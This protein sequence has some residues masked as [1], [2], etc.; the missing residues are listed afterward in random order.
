MTE[1]EA[2]QWVRERF[3]ASRETLLSRF[4][5]LVVAESAVQNLVSAATLSSIW[6]RHIVDSAQ[7]L[8]LAEDAKGTWIDIGTGAGFPGVVVAALRDHPIILV[9]PRKRRAEFL[10][11][12]VAELGL[13]NHATIAASKAE[14]VL[15]RA[16]V[17][18]ARAVAPLPELLS[19]AAHLSDS[20]TVWLLPKG[21]HARQEV[22]EAQR[23]WQ[24]MFHVEQSLTHPDSLII[25]AQGISRR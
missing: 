18:S 5:E 2:R 17:I 8:S 1:A 7:L 14:A 20:S 25:V 11:N 15:A 13:T 9:E 12:V 19:A 10:R 6:D 21:C 4:A 16:S 24:G 23:T 3:G 22:A